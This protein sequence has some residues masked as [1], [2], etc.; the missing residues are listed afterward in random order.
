MGIA[1]LFAHI[2]K[3][4][5]QELDGSQPI[6]IHVAFI[7]LTQDQ[8]EHTALRICIIHIEYILLAVQCHDSQLIRILRESNAGNIEVAFY[9]DLHLFRVFGDYAIRMYGDL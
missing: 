6:R 1:I 9:R 3:P 4:I 8:T 5:V 7:F 2:G